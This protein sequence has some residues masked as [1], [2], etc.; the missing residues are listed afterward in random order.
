MKTRTHAFHV[1][2]LAV[3][4]MAA[5]VNVVTVV[6]IP[7]QIQRLETWDMSVPM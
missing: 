2:L 1:A 3:A 4:A 7:L 6:S 5:V